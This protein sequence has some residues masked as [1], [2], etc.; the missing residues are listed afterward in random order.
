VRRYL[1]CAAF[2]SLVAVCL[3]SCGAGGSYVWVN[4]LPPAAAPPSDGRYRIGAGDLISVRVYEQD[5]MSTRTK[6][7]LDGNVSLPLVGEV[8]VRGRHPT[9]VA[10]E[11]EGRLKQYVNSPVVTVSVDESQLIPVSVVGEVAHPGIFQLDPAAGVLQALAMAG[12]TTEY[13]DK[14]RIFVLRK[15]QPNPVRIR[16]TFQSLTRNDAKAVTFAL[17]AGD[18]VVVE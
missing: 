2:L 16:F 1:L 9:E 15:Q 12:G 17:L 6:V 13:A 7:R 3:A 4:D 5:N 18:V 8:Q 14:D 11:V 10:K